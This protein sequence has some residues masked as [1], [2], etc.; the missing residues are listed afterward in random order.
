MHTLADLRSGTLAGLT[1]INLSD[2]LTKFPEEIFELADSL[3]ILDLSN[4]LLEML[5]DDMHRLHKLKVVF[6]S[7]NQFKSLPVCL[8]LCEKL[9]MVGFKSN[10]IETVAPESLPKNL[11]W[12]ILTDNKIGSLPDSIGLHTRLQKLMLA[13]NQLEKL[14]DSLANCRKLQLLRVS[15]NKLKSFPEVVFKL[16]EL[17]WVAFSG[18]PFCEKNNHYIEAKRCAFDDLELGEVLGQGASGVISKGEWREQKSSENFSG[19]QEFAVKVFKG[20]VTS[21]GYPKD[22]LDVCLHMGSHENLVSTFA[23]CD[24][25]KGSAALMHLIPTGYENLGQPPSLESCSRDVFPESLVLTS[26][27]VAALVSQLERAV[28]YLHEHE[29]AHGDIYAHNVLVDESYHLLFGDFGA[30][31]D[32][33]YLTA[34]IKE[35][36][37]KIEKRALG[38]FI[39][40]LLAC[41][42]RDKSTAY[43]AQDL[44]RSLRDKSRLLIRG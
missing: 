35:Q 17:A 36:V 24:D 3:E 43:E 40:D 7:E 6:C 28:N 19:V 2:N 34:E 25:D 22:E 12:L 27:T 5:P 21:D 11:R 23:Y 37:K 44:V 32:F 14:P 8:G 18:N 42:E 15:A 26:E 39:E 20:S 41:L 16:P 29:I 1:R 4:N 31:S 10:Q 30:S 9:E 13:G 38:Y 33:S